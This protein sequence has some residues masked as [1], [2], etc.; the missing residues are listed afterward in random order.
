MSIIDRDQLLLFDET[1]ENIKRQT[2]SV[3]PVRVVYPEAVRSKV[4]AEIK[5][6]KR[7]V[8]ENNGV[9]G[10]IES[11]DDAE[12]VA[13]IMAKLKYGSSH[14][15]FNDLA[16]GLYSAYT[17]KEG[18]SE[19]R[20]LV[21]KETGRPEK[22]LFTLSHEA[23]YKLMLGPLVN[24][25][26]RAISGAGPVVREIKDQILPILRGEQVEPTACATI[27]KVRPDGVRIEAAVFGKPIIIDKWSTSAARIML[28]HYFFPI[29]ESDTIAGDKYLNQVAGL[30]AFLSFGRF[31]LRQ[32]QGGSY[33]Q[34]PDAHKL[35]LSLQAAFEMRGFAPG[36]VK[37]NSLGRANVTLR[38]TAVKDLRPEAVASTGRIDFRAF[39]DFVSRVGQMY[40]TA[41]D[42]TGI[43]AQLPHDV[44]IPATERGAEFPTNPRVVFIKVDKDKKWKEK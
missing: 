44:L 1:K 30:T 2:S 18:F 6:G 35:I 24:S 10:L 17:R 5:S 14:I 23:I 12:Y 42:E 38:R 20:Q 33:P 11:R 3:I 32:R 27:Q 9:T 25:N 28:D 43:E 31:L 16:S 19:A 29:L 22:T 4:A 15:L 36:I 39:S 40:R 34:T 41:L 7:A 26:G 13:R 21:D 8:F 37:E